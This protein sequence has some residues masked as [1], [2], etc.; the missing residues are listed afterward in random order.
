MTFDEQPLHRQ[1]YARQIFAKAG[2]TENPR[3]L[4]AFAS[5]AREDFV[6]PPP[7]YFN[8]FSRYRE[9]QSTDPVVL[10]QDI[11]VGLDK[12]SGVNNGMPSLHAGALNALHVREGET[13]FHMGTGTGYYA[14]ILSE[15]VGSSGK[16]FAVEYDASLAAR[17]REN[18][19]TYQNVE[20]I[21]GDATV[22]PKDDAD[23]IYTNFALDHPPSA[24]IEN[25]AVSGRLLFPLGFPDKREGREQAFTRAGGF[26]MVDRQARGLGARFLQPVSFI[27]VRGQEETPAGRHE[28]LAKAFASKS[29]YRV[30]SLRWQQQPTG[31]EWYG[32]DEWGL[33]FDEV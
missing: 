20:V 24:W 23:V 16:V 33:S 2:V 25:L 12:D 31:Q 29:A 27:W 15:L 18:L 3:L 1:I 4:N 5:V 8:D 22:L 19:K 9:L 26:L 28:G 10:Y 11:L 30:R 7:W 32:E 17:A 6:G 13:V 14:A 21:E